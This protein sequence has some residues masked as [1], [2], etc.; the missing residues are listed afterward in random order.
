MN[1]EL[2]RRLLAG[3]A[4][5]DGEVLCA[6]ETEAV[7]LIRL[8]LRPIVRGLRATAPSAVLYRLQDWYAAGGPV[9]TGSVTSWDLVESWLRS[10]QSLFLARTGEEGIPLGIYPDDYSFYL[11]FY[12]DHEVLPGQSLDGSY[13]V[14]G[15]GE[16]LE[17][18]R[19]ALRADDVLG[20]D[21]RDAVS[22]FGV[23]GSRTH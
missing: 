22:Y 8:A 14:C 21:S 23:S 15:S 20:W 11:R 3:E 17:D 4:P 2:R 1:V 7:A 12:V 18:L 16:L 9:T 6:K 13:D 10:D 5:F 19:E